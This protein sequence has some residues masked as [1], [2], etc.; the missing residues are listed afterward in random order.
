MSD[1][2]QAERTPVE[3]WPPAWLGP[4]FQILDGRGPRSGEI[5]APSTPAADIV[6][7]EPDR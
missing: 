2:D 6:H 7:V 5:D 4:K 1:R 3:P